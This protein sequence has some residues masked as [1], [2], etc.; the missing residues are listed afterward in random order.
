MRVPHGQR[1]TFEQRLYRQVHARY[2]RNNLSAF[3]RAEKLGVEAVLVSLA[4]IIERDGDNCYLCGGWMSVHEMSFEHV[5]PLSRGGT[6]TPDNIKA[7]HRLCNFRKST[8]LVEEIPDLSTWE[9]GGKLPSLT[10]HRC[11]RCY[12]VKA[13][14]R[15]RSRYCGKECSNIALREQNLRARESRQ[16]AVT[17]EICKA[18]KKVRPHRAKTFRF[19]SRKCRGKWQ[20][21]QKFNAKNG[22]TSLIC[23]P[24]KEHFETYHP[25][26]RFCSPVCASKHHKVF[27]LQLRACERLLRAS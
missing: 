6:H 12:E 9:Y 21:T 4:S 23:E 20:A 19:C 15:K 13:S 14:Q 27:M 8:R 1:L 7:A 5:I 18:V 25:R 24:C 26:Q 17:C 10:C 2:E 11:G 22:K 3:R 16:V